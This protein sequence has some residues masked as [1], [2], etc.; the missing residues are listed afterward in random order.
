MREALEIDGR[1]VIPLCMKL[2]S[3]LVKV[4]LGICKGKKVFD[5]REVLK[6]KIIKRE[7]EAAIKG[8][9]HF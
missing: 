4:E 7:S 9:K 3:G 5:K 2:I 6:E 8:W 1:A